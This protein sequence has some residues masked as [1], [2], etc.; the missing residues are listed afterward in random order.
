MKVYIENKLVSLRGNSSVKDE[1]QKEVFYVKGKLVSPTHKKFVQDMNKNTLY[2][3]R[4]KWI[5][6]F[7]HSAYIYDENK[8]KIAKVK[9]PFF[10]S[11]KKYLVQGYKDE[12]VVSGDFFSLQSTII[13]NGHEIGTMIREF[14]V[15][16]DSFVLEANEADIPF[17]IA[18]VIAVDNIHDKATKKK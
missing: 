11:K 12:I 5:N 4:N 10:S 13:K 2:I 14:N 16:V 1:N 15:M 9:H 3:V 17:L 18:L 8:N 6:F 7:S